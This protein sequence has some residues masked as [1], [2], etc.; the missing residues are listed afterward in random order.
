MPVIRF[1]NNANTNA[2]DIARRAQGR[3]VFANS[4]VNQKSLDLNCLNRVAAGPAATTSFS[5]SKYIDQR[6]GTIFT[7]QELAA[8]IVV[9]S[10]CQQPQQPAVPV[11]SYPN[12]VLE[13][14]D[15][16]GIQVMATGT[17]TSF[18]FTTT[19]LGAG[20]LEFQFYKDNS[21]FSNQLVVLGVDSSLITP[22]SDTDEVRYVFR[23][24]PIAVTLSCP[25][26]S[27]FLQ[28][29]LPYTFTYEANTPGDT[30]TLTLYQYPSD[31]PIEYEVTDGVPFTPTSSWGY[32]SWDIPC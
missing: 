8:E 14:S 4:L 15:S 6:V 7:T 28:W 5:G 2:S 11:I 13:C 22:P 32:N 24:N 26:E 29:T 20:V 25:G 18:T 30:T 27:R 9:K 21:Y 10:P 23:C 31:T 17:F 1:N 3:A 19:T 16:L 12:Y